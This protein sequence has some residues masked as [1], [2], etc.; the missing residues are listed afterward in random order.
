MSLSE[1]YPSVIYWHA[2]S[3]CGSDFQSRFEL[4]WQILTVETGDSAPS[5]PLSGCLALPLPLSCPSTYTLLCTHWFT[6]STENWSKRG[7]GW[8]IRLKLDSF[9]WVN[10]LNRQTAVQI[11]DQGGMGGYHSEPRVGTAG[12]RAR[13]LR[14]GGGGKSLSQFH[15]WWNHVLWDWGSGCRGKQWEKFQ[16]CSSW[17]VSS[18]ASAKLRCLH[19]YLFKATSFKIGFKLISVL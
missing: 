17:S 10:H 9:C 5:L 4:N 19:L 1:S 16:L 8:S 11:R 13:A 6:P 15:P 12:G 3:T 18:L 7:R 14:F 2:Y